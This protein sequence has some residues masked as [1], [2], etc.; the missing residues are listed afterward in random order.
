MK[1]NLLIVV[2]A[3][4]LC[5]SCA[6]YVGP[7][8]AGVAIGVPSPY[9]AAPASPSYTYSGHPYYHN[10]DRLYYPPSRNNWAQDR[11]YRY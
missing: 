6:A 2:L 7:H 9:V 5:V 8:G 3:A 10:N 11:Y 4:L 1:N